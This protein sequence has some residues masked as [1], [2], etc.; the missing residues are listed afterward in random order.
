MVFHVL[1]IKHFNYKG[2]MFIG[3]HIQNIENIH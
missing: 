3:G 1:K 2:S